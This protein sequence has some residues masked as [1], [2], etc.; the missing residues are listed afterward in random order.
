MCLETLWLLL[1]QGIQLLQDFLLCLILH[2]HLVS[3]EGPQVPFAQMNP[4]GLDRR[5]LQEALVVQI[6][7]GS[8]SAQEVLWSQTLPLNRLTCPEVLFFHQT[9]QPSG[10]PD[11]LGALGVPEVLVHRADLEHQ[12]LHHNPQSPAVQAFLCV[13]EILFLLESRE[14]PWVQGGL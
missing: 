12:V 2:L 13:H 8:R 11:L 10:I 7:Q 6:D 14:V 9:L 3:L 1:I 5:H 4:C